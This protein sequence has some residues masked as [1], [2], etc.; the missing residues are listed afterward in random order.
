MENFSIEE[1]ISR[2]LK[3]YNLESVGIVFLESMLPFRR[4]MG[5]LVVFNEPFLSLFFNEKLLQEL[6]DLFYNEKKYY[7][8]YELLKEDKKPD[9][10]DQ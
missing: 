8:L 3:Q 5:H 7:Q 4:I 2:I 1:K 6:Q 9:P 10:S